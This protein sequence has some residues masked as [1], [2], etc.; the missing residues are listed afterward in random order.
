MK[1]QE[2]REIAK[3][4]GI[5]GGKM[6]KQE[7]IRAIQQDEGNEPCFATGRIETCEQHG[8]LWRNDCSDS[9]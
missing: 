3:E 6:K 2:I 4:R 5:K 8:C 7:L 1:L 9:A